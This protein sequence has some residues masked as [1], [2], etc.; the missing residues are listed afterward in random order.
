MRPSGEVEHLKWLIFRRR[1]LIL[2]VHREA[3]NLLSIGDALAVIPSGSNEI[4]H[5][6]RWF[7]LRFNHRLMATILSGSTKRI[8]SQPGSESHVAVHSEAVNRYNAR[9]RS[10]RPRGFSLRENA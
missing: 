3:V 6:Y 5:N 1:R 8:D 9:S 2:T 10:E 7:S 4:G